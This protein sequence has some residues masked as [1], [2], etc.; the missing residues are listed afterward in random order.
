[1]RENAQPIDL[2]LTD[3]FSNGKM[4][5]QSLIKSDVDLLLDTDG[6]SSL[7][8]YESS[9]SVASEGF[10]WIIERGLH[11]GVHSIFIVNSRGIESFQWDK[12]WN[13]LCKFSSLKTFHVTHSPNSDSGDVFRMFYGGD[14]PLQCWPELNTLLL[15]GSIS[16]INMSTVA[17]S[18]PKLES[19]NFGRD[20]PAGPRIV[21]DFSPLSALKYLK[22]LST[23]PSTVF[24]KGLFGRETNG[25]LKNLCNLRGKQRVFNSPIGL[26]LLTS[27][28]SLILDER[29][30]NAAAPPLTALKSLRELSVRGCNFNGIFP[31]SWAKLDLRTIVV[32]FNNFTGSYPEK[33]CLAGSRRYRLKILV[34]DVDERHGYG[35]YTFP[36]EQQGLVPSWK[37]SSS[38]FGQTV[39]REYSC[40]GCQSCGCIEFVR[41]RFTADEGV[42]LNLTYAFRRGLCDG[43]MNTDVPDTCDRYKDTG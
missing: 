38:D 40:Q 35:R 31:S 2:H 20:P 9:Y 30:F 19:L 5:V 18:H 16:P 41:G 21:G 29:Q 28:S 25:I 3:S 43:V 17:S 10:S 11:P 15:G 37:Q 26:G 8:V 33:L 24:Y 23:R 13:S 39:P 42:R 12:F 1:M 34:G 4:S 6:V 32:S 14:E 36:I 7:H 22:H 27:L